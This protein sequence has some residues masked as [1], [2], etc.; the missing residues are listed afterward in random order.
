MT[1]LICDYGKC[2][3]P[4]PYICDKCRSYCCEEHVKAGEFWQ[5]DADDYGF[6][7]REKGTEHCCED[8]LE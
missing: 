7:V 4:A 5:K 2:S 1:A 8:C 3:E 6:A